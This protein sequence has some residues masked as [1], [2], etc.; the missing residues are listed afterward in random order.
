MKNLYYII[1]FT[2]IVLNSCELK[3]ELDFKDYVSFTPALVVHG[4]ISPNDCVRVT[5]S[6]SAPIDNTGYDTHV[7]DAR[8]TLTENGVYKFDLIETEPGFFVSPLSFVPDKN[9]GYQIKVTAEGLKDA[10]SSVQ[11][12]LEPIEID[13]LF[14]KKDTGRYQ[15]YEL[16]FK[17]N[18]PGKVQ[19]FYHFKQAITD[20]PLYDYRYSEDLSQIY[21][22]TDDKDFNGL[23]VKYRMRTYYSTYNPNDSILSVFLFNLSPDL[24]YFLQ[25]MSEYDYTHGDPLFAN[26]TKIYS[27]IKGGYGIFASYTYTVKHLI[28]KPDS[29]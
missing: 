28:I 14:I 25:S 21:G 15:R 19:N 20:T 6:K 27:N 11:F 22:S 5:I 13:T 24:H 16:F 12:L 9:F 18:D 29:L 8:V 10:T 4:F 1:L 3:K 2:P 23:T 17:F 7:N 26:P